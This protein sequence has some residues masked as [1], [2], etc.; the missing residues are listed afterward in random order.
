MLKFKNPPVVEVI[1][2]IQWLP[3]AQSFHQVD[4]TLNK[5]LLNFT[6]K[7]AEVDFCQSERLMPPQVPIMPFQPIIKYNKVKEKNYFYQIGDGIFSAHAIPPYESWEEFKPIVKSGIELLIGL[8]PKKTKNKPIMFESAYLRYIDIFK[9]NMFGDVIFE[10]FI[11]KILKIDPPECLMD[12]S[13][14]N[15]PSIQDIKISTLLKNNMNLITVT[16]EFIG[17]STNKEDFILMDNTLFINNNL[18]TAINIM[19]SMDEAHN[20]ISDVFIKMTEPIHAHM[21]RINA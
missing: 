2:A 7:V 3:S 20:I 12:K 10:E 8:M 17:A 15:K 16:K 13:V 1:A 4:E 9:K 19:K 5:M 18:D 6:D 21:E 14:A 11:S